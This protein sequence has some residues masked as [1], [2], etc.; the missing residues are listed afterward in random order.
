MIFRF[1]SF[2]VVASANQFM[3]FLAKFQFFLEYDDCGDQL[4]NKIH[5]LKIVNGPVII[6]WSGSKCNI[7]RQ[8]AFFDFGKKDTIM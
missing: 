7:F 4:S 6:S 8:I 1:K 2:Y 5:L 3:H